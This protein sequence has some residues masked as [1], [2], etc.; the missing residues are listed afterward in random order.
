MISDSPSSALVR[1]AGPTGALLRSRT[2]SNPINTS[3][4]AA[5]ARR[6]TRLAAVSCNRRLQL[7]APAEPAAESA[8]HAKRNE[9]P[10]RITTD[11][12][13]PNA[14]TTTMTTIEQREKQLQQLAERL[15]LATVSAAGRRQLQSDESRPSVSPTRSIASPLPAFCD[16]VNYFS[17]HASR[18]PPPLPDDLRAVASARM[19]RHA[20]PLLW[21]RWS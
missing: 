8:R 9:R 18:P 15:G 19:S 4:R 10:A 16:D 5:S 1:S 17:P 7:L 21:R 3:G 13:Q 12:M 2:G 20:R 14:T 6:I 11:R